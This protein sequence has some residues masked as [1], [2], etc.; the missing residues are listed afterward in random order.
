MYSEKKV[1]SYRNLRGVDFSRSESLV[2]KNHSPYC[3]NM[4]PDSSINPV[5]RPGWQTKYSLSEEIYNIW[6]C[7][8]KGKKYM[9][10]HCGD[11]IYRLG[12]EAVL[13][14]EGIGK[15]KGCGFYAIS[16]DKG[17][18]YILTTEELLRFD[19][20]K[21]ERVS[22]FGY[23]PLVTI[24]KGPQG[25]GESY[26]DINLLSEVRRESFIGTEEELIYQLG[27]DNISGVEKVE[28]LQEDGSY[29]TLTK[30]TDYTVDDTLGKIT[31]VSAKPTPLSGHD[32]IIVTYRKKV[33]G[34]REQI[35][36]CTISTGFGLGGENRIFLSG[37]PLCPEKDFWSDVHRPEYFPDLN[38]AVVGSGQTAVM[39]YLRLGEYLGIVKESNGQDTSLFLRRA[40]KKEN[41]D[42]LFTVHSGISGVGAISKNCF[43]VLGDEP[44]F[45]SSRGIFAVANS[46]ITS[47]KV[48]ANRSYQ[49][50]AK[51]VKEDNLADAVAC[52]WKDF[53]I[54]SVNGN[55]YLLDSR[56][57]APAKSGEKNSR[58]EAY[59]WNNV[60]ARSFAVDGDTL[61]FGTADGHIRF[62]KNE[63]IGN[64]C[65]S[66]DGAAIYAVWKTAVEDEGCIERFK[67]LMRKGCLVSLKPF[68]TSSCKVYY[69][70]D[71][72]REQ[73]VS[74]VLL[75]ITGAFEKVDFS[76]FTFYT[77]TNPQELYFNKRQ[78]RYKRI[79]L[80]FENDQPDEGFGLME[81]V[82]T[83]KIIGHSKNRR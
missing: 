83:Y 16:G 73:L 63:D 21:T 19:G 14:T 52:V 56:Q 30:D 28:S 66:D 7:T 38:Y 45:L 18:F 53:Y 80:I 32:N 34:Y 33:E 2:D 74:A 82:K 37:N 41:G 35:E 39:G 17:Y 68:E 10:C 78:K 46:T 57:I 31:F 51:L 48:I 12:D 47:E 64:E 5:K 3:L 9:L 44:L 61:W 58:Y 75:D 40:E 67:T 69:S 26:E 6:F 70:V 25:G 71:G 15:G 59:F 76:R 55:C 79:Q 4:M 27:T 23:A 54:L 36:K 1:V 77:N 8:I 60:A 62:F 22:D 20:E 43:A 42:A 49:V 13:L 29:T 65:Y 50:D 11:K 24:A 72:G 81:I